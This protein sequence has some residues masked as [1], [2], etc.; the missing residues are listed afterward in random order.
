MVVLVTG[1]A[2]FIG[3]AVVRV[4]LASNRAV[5]NVDKLTYAA[6]LESL[7]SAER[8]PR[9]AFVKA[10]ICDPDAMRA[11]FAQHA[12]DAVIHLAAESHVDRSID[13]PG[14]FVQANVVGT[15]TL[16]QAARAHWAALPSERR[17]AF[18]FVHV[19]T[20]EVFGSLP[21]GEWF[22][23]GRPYAPSSPYAASKASADHFVRAWHTTFGLP[24]LVTSSSNNFGPYQFP[25]KL[26]PLTIL[27]AL[28]GKPLPIYGTG[29]QERDW[30][31]VDDHAAA[32]VSAVERGRPG[33]TY[34]LGAR[35]PRRNL[36][37]VRAICGYVDELAPNQAIG[38]RESL[39]RFVTDRPGH[40]ERYALD[41]TESEAALGWRPRHGFDE[42]LRKTVL[43]YLENRAWCERLA[44]RGYA[45]ERLGLGETFK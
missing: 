44:G 37:V 18:R 38:K 11:V 9:Y 5:V 12:P 3:S 39:I 17:D 42:A 32:L 41:P 26:I 33:A 21:E 30:L 23:P 16:L 8:D 28:E 43:W 40:D 19:S 31:F 35:N 6:D 20:D 7:A 15:F 2:G 4:L 22:A 14:D 45:R 10:D 34:L 27:N 29:T 13:A 36:D 25:E 1:G 24:S